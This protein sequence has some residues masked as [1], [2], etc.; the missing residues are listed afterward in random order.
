M[1]L[2]DFDQCHCGHERRQHTA[3]GS[4]PLDGCDKFR[5]QYRYLANE[6]PPPTAAQATAAILDAC[7]GYLADLLTAWMAD[8]AKPEG[9][10]HMEARGTELL[11]ALRARKAARG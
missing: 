9:Q 5:L 10:L 8:D 6:A 11:N 2:P 3:D 4:A 1:S 7:E